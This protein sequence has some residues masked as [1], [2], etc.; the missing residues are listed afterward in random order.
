MTGKGLIRA[1]L[2]AAVVTTLPASATWAQRGG[3]S[4]IEGA[5]QT[6]TRDCEGGPAVVE[7]ASNTVR[8]TGACSG[9]RI[10]GASNIITIDLAP[11]AIIRVTGASNEVRW[12]M[13]GNARPRQV[14][15]GA[16]NH[17]SRAR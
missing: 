3:G 13:P 4:S 2:V 11:G 12:S 7:G 6:G 10:E 17:I 1:C 5:G 16:A 14:V 9:L 15:E 8:F